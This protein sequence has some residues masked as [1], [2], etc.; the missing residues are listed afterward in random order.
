MRRR[1]LAALLVAPVLASLPLSGTVAPGGGEALAQETPTLR[2]TA[3][4]ELSPR[5]EGDDG[6]LSWADVPGEMEV[7]F[8]PGDAL[9]M[10]RVPVQLVAVAV[11]GGEVV[12]RSST[13]PSVV[14]AG[15][16]LPA[17]RLAGEGWPAAGDLFGAG[18]WNPVNVSA[19]DDPTPADAEAAAS[20]VSPPSDGAAVVLFAAPAADELAERFRT[21]PLAVAAERAGD[22]ADTDT[23][24][25]DAP[26]EAGTGG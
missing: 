2:L 25:L 24:T 20:A 14:S 26:R 6:Q 4:E 16:S 19:P 10:E 12:G 15:E 18:D 5:A 3:P 9:P 8:V 13:T 1:H 22:P 21:L 17:S 11:R 23:T 7:E